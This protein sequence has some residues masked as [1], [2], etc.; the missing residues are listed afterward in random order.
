M[1]ERSI[2]LARHGY[3][4]DY[5]DPDWRRTAK[6][7]HDTPLSADGLEQARE[8]AIRLEGEGLRHVLSSPFL[9]AVETANAV[10]EHLSLPLCIE[11]GACEWLRAEWFPSMPAVLSVEELAPEFPQVDPA[12]EPCCVPRYPEGVAEL[13]ARCRTLAAVLAERFGGDFL[14][15]GHGASVTGLTATFLDDPTVETHPTMCAVTKLTGADGRWCLELDGDRSHLAAIDS[16]QMREMPYVIH[17]HDEVEREFNRRLR[18]QMA[19]CWDG[20]GS[21]ES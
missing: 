20:S 7:P 4:A 13:V 19:A 11:P 16:R 14:V 3:R 2:W 5:V 15:V 8:L 10:A 12:Y 21:Q 9:R 1:E 6:R 17:G 18:A